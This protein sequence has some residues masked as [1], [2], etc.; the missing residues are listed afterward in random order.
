MKFTVYGNPTGKGRPKFSRRGNFVH[1]YTPEKTANYEDLV[2]I[3][4]NQA[5]TVEDLKLFDKPLKVDIKAFYP[6][7][8]NPITK[9]KFNKK[10]SALALSNDIKAVI[11]PDVDNVIKIILDALNGVAYKDDNQIV[12]LTAEKIYSTNPRVEIEIILAD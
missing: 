8:T 11:K 6:T 1:T 2:I 10:E 7:T 12:K 5:K 3:S 4:Y 9:K